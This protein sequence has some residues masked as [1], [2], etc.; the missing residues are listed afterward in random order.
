MIQAYA[1]LNKDKN[2][3]L[4]SSSGGIFYSLAKKVL[5]EAG[6]VFGAA[7]NADW[8]VDMISVNR[9]EDLPKIMKSKYISAN[10][11]DTYKE[12]KDYLDKGIKVLYSGIPCQI[13]GLKAYLKQEYDN[14][15]T[16]D[17]CCHGIMPLIIWK[18][19]LKSLERESPITSIDM[20]DKTPGWKSYNFTVKYEDGFVLT[21][22]HRQNKYM[23]DFLSDAYLKPSCYRCKF[24]NEYSKADIIL[25][26]YWSVDLLHKNLNDDTGVN[27]VIV[28]TEKGNLIIK[29]LNDITLEP[30]DINIAKK[31]NGGMTNEINTLKIK[32]YVFKN[33]KYTGIITLP[34]HTNFGG[35]LQNYA[36][37]KVL[38]SLG[39]IPITLDFRN[40][41]KEHFT[42]FCDKNIRFLLYQNIMD[43]QND[44]N[45]FDNII[46]GSDQV[47]RSE[48]LNPEISFLNMCKNWNCNKVYY[49]ASSGYD[50]VNTSK[51]KIDNIVIPNL[52]NAT[53]VSTR[54]TGLQRYL[55]NDLKIPSSVQCDPTILLQK[56]D[57]EGL[58]SNIKE[59]TNCYGYYI[60]DKKGYVFNDPKVKSRLKIEPTNE[61]EFLAMYRDADF[62]ITDSYHGCLFSLIF[63]KPFICKR[64]TKRGSSRFDTLIEIFNLDK[65]IV[66]SFE[67][68]NYDILDKKPNIDLTDVRKKG[69]HFLKNNLK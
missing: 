53:V 9:I 59:R 69:I 43:F 44:S 31:F 48:W 26:D 12:C 14:L 3:R 13:W 42:D 18:D 51:E 20:R 24:K 50:N 62:I 33:I 8:F 66:D 61:N 25:G 21:E 27:V 49:A 15:I 46:V 34:L 6:I 32:P 4:K 65:Y 58:Y 5:S 67:N 54:E 55:S 45:R 57:Y 68:L 16:I 52:N 35:N 17:V 10:I 23:Q 60:L 38:T 63:N 36:L 22:S 64:N 1:A 40:R 28:N 11:K 41:K 7:W 30:T 29:E 47:W 39:K 56:E 2:I 37:Q 19:Y